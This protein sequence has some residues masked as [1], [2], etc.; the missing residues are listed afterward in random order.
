[1][2]FVPLALFAVA[3]LGLGCAATVL[4]TDWIPDSIGALASQHG[5]F[6]GLGEQRGK[7]V[8][9]NRARVQAEAM[10]VVRTSN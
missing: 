8:A 4:L 6:V 2:E 1:M 7:A 10:N 5:R 9:P 3:V